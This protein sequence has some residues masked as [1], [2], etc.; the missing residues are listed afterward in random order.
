MHM[1]RYLYLKPSILDVTASRRPFSSSNAFQIL[2][3]HKNDRR[4]NSYFG[5]M[6][7][8]YIGRL[9]LPDRT[10]EI[11]SL[12]YNLRPIRTGV[13]SYWSF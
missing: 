3:N 4:T 11:S 8:R 1:H 13:F 5:A 6:A 2:I 12:S 10:Y 7:S 9:D